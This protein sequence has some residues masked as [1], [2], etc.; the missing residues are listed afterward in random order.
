MADD[1]KE[2]V[3]RCIRVQFLGRPEYLIVA[4]VMRQTSS[5]VYQQIGA[6]LGGTGMARTR[7]EVY[8]QAREEH[9]G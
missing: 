1:I 6:V 9:D 4:R 2:Q 8:A 3:S 5:S 7:I